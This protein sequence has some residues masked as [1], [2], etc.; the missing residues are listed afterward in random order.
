MGGG[1]VTL[2][3]PDEVPGAVRRFRAYRAREEDRDG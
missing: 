3:H 2:L 1:S